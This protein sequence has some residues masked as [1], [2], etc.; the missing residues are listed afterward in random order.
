MFIAEH[1]IVTFHTLGWANIYLMNISNGYQKAVVSI[2]DLNSSSGWKTGLRDLCLRA[3]YPSTPPCPSENK[4]KF[5]N[6]CC[7][8]CE[9]NNSV[10][11]CIIRSIWN[12][13]VNIWGI[14]S[15]QIARFAA[16]VWAAGR[17]LN[18][19]SPRQRAR[20]CWAFDNQGDPWHSQVRGTLR[21]TAGA[22]DHRFLWA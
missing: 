10:A 6:I 7:E 9:G 14:H 16:A 20:N 8:I 22:S 13:H 3:L 4:L 2:G 1:G 5:Q 15:V 19:R 18:S 17:A 21:A 12:F 11:R